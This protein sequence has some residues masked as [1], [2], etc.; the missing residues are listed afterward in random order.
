MYYAPVLSVPLRAASR[1][2]FL[3]VKIRSVF[4]R[5]M[6]AISDQ[7]A[8]RETVPSL[9]TTMGPR[10][11]SA[12]ALPSISNVVVVVASL[13]TSPGAGSAGGRGAA[14]EASPSVLPSPSSPASPAAAGCGCRAAASSGPARGAAT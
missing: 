14:A 8:M 2:W 7:F 6:S 4:S 13:P 9:P 12:T 11:S 1:T 5:S 3:L 10:W